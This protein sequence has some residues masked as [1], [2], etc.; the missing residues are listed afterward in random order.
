MHDYKINI[1][2]CGRHFAKVELP[3]GTDEQDA[4]LA[5]AIFR[6]KMGEGFDIT[7]TK[8]TKPIGTAVELD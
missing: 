1:A 2:T 3:I 5:L 8:W 6:S 4:K 7:L